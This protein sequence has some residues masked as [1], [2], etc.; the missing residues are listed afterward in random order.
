MFMSIVFLQKDTYEA[1]N[2][3]KNTG[4]DGVVLW[5]SSSDLNSKYVFVYVSL[6]AIEITFI[7]SA[8]L[9]PLVIINPFIIIY[10]D[11]NVINFIITWKTCWVRSHN[12]FSH[13]ML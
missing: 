4:G 5:G 10:L 11:R 3:I 8:I 1:L 13:D 12:H 6:A 2:A 7:F 9:L